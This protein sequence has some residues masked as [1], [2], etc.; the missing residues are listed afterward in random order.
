MVIA[1]LDEATMHRSLFTATFNEGDL[2]SAYGQCADERSMASEER[3]IATTHGA[4]TR[5]AAL[6][7]PRPVV[8]A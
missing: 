3:D 1:D 8:A 2:D 4:R 5:P 6:A 7:Q